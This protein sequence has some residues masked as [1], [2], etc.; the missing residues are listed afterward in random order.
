MVLSESKASKKAQ[1]AKGFLERNVP[2]PTRTSTRARGPTTTSWLPNVRP[3][4]RQVFVIFTCSCECA[5][6]PRL[7]RRLTTGPCPRFFRAAVILPFVLVLN[8]FLIAAFAGFMALYSLPGIVPHGDIHRARL[9]FRCVP[10]R[11][12]IRT[13]S[14]RPFHSLIRS[15]HAGGDGLE[16]HAAQRLRRLSTARASTTIPA[17]S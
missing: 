2:D 1:A 12:A 3:A 8:L 10:S 6:Y 17:G 16:L 15:R 9:R 7:C 14:S 11:R 5:R 4:G 13:A